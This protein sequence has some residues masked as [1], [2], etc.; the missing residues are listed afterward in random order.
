VNDA[1]SLCQDPT[2]RL[3]GSEKVWGRGAALTSRLQSF[4]IELL[5]P[6]E[7]LAGLEAINRGL[8]APAVTIDSRQ[9]VVPEMDSTEPGLRTTG[10]RRLEWPFRVHLLSPPVA[11]QRRGELPGGQTSAG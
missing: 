6:D 11:G 8:I 2:L 7:N 5:A 1:E 4:E 10:A 9:R 3:I